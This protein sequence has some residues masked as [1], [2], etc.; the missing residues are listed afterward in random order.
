MQEKKIAGVCAGLGEYFEVDPIFFR[1]FFIFLLFIT[2]IGFLLYVIMWIL[3]PVH[4]QDKDSSQAL[5]RIYLSSEDCKIAGV[6]GGLG[7]FFEVDPVFYR[8]AFIVFTL[9]FGVGILGYIILWLVIP[10]KRDI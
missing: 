9:F 2:G 5:R 8:I 3:V 6:C 1:I 10:R 4:D 7:V